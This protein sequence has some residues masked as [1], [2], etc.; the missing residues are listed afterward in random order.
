MTNHKYEKYKMWKY[1]KHIKAQDIHP[2][3]IGLLCYQ[4]GRLLLYCENVPQVNNWLSALQC[5]NKHYRIWPIFLN[6]ALQ[7]TWFKFDLQ[8]V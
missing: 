6:C 5:K 4:H 1:E 7:G 2:E 3:M 8:M